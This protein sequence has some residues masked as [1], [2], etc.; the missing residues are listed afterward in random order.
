MNNCWVK[1]R[2]EAEAY[3]GGGDGGGFEIRILIFQGHDLLKDEH[4]VKCSIPS[5]DD[6]KSFLANFGK[7]KQFFFFSLLSDS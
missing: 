2:G 1:E 4:F 7:V 6:V 3:T 5:I